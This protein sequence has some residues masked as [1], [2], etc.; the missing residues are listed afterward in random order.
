[1]KPFALAL[2]S[3]FSMQHSST[4]VWLGLAPPRVK[5]FCW[6]AVKGKVSTAGNLRTKGLVLEN[7]Q[8]TCYLCGKDFESINHFFMHCEVSSLIRKH[9]LDRLVCCGGF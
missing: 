7:F 4:K 2:E 5:A 6:L 1:M 8:E 3:S 9:F